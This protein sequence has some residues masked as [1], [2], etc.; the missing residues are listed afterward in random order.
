MEKY[1]FTIVTVVIATSITAISY[2][3]GTHQ[4]NTGVCPSSDILA[5]II[6]YI[7]SAIIVVMGRKLDKFVSSDLVSL[8]ELVESS[9]EEQ[10]S[11]DDMARHNRHK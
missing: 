9:K 6:G 1:K 4:I 11:M 7:T 2:V 8:N 3:I 10:S 5:M